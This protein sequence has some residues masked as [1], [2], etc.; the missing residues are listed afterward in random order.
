MLALKGII[1]LRYRDDGFYSID[2]VQE[3][4]YKIDLIG[5]LQEFIQNYGKSISI[6]YWI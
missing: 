2:L 3:D 5:R 6:K 1:Q 4:G